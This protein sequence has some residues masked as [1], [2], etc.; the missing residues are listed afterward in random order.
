MLAVPFLALLGLVLV[1]LWRAW[2]VEST[3]TALVRRLI[4]LAVQDQNAA[5]LLL[6]EHP[7]LLQA[8]YLHDE[9]PLHFCAVE[10]FTAGVRFFARAGVP[11]DAA[12]RFGD[13]PLTDAAALGNLEVVRLLLHHGADPNAKSRTREC[14][15]HDAVSNGHA[16]VV[17]AL[18]DAGARADYVTTLGETVWDALP[19]S[20]SGRD[21]LS[22]VL[23]RR[24]AKR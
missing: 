11:V 17:A 3:D 8:R 5:G 16:E 23:E 24:G 22:S 18:L 2:A 14:V 6:R 13:T 7:E 4:D 1:L 19:K 20:G 12:N 15:L 9:T 21:E 10:G